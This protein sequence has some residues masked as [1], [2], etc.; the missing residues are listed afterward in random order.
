MCAGSRTIDAGCIILK[1]GRFQVVLHDVLQVSSSL[2]IAEVIGQGQTEINAN[3]NR[4]K[5]GIK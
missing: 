3:I 5:E 1:S 4:T 2:L